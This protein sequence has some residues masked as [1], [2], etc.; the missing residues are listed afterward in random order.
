[1][2]RL[3]LKLF[4]LIMGLALFLPVVIIFAIHKEN[5][6]APERTVKVD[7][8]PL[9]GELRP[10][11]LRRGMP[12]GFI[13]KCSECHRAF[14]TP[15]RFDQRLAEHRDIVLDH[16]RNDYCLNCHHQTNR[17]AYVTHDGREIPADEPAQ[18]CA[19]CH[20]IVYRDWEA[21]AHGRRHGHWDPAQ[22]EREQLL[23]IQCH[24]PHAPKIEGLTPLP[25]PRRVAIEDTGEVH[26]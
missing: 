10:L 8:R 20:G 4:F 11:R 14:Q 5:P 7:Y 13:Y 18:L 25:G 17:D 15:R 3:P 9:R 2:S 19:K 16:G 12:T 21:G 26:K 1:M 23:C 24:D 6:V 22:G